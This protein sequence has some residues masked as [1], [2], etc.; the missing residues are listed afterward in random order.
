MTTMLVWVL[1]T[2]GGAN[3][4]LATYSPPFATEAECQRVSKVLYDF[5]TGSSVKPLCVQM[6]IVK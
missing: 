5:K 2:I 3:G 6:T 1:V 4:P